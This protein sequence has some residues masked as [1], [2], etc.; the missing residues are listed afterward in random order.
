MYVHRISAK[1]SN[2]NMLNAFAVGLLYIQVD[3]F[4]PIYRIWLS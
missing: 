3:D 4:E 1:K 2:A